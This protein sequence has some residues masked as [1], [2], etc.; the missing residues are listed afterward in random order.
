MSAPKPPKPPKPA[1]PFRAKPLYPRGPAA[2]PARADPAPRAVNPGAI[3]AVGPARAAVVSGARIMFEEDVAM[4]GS[5]TVDRGRPAAA[6]CSETAAGAVAA[7]KPPPMTP[8]WQ[9]ATK[10]PQIIKNL[11]MLMSC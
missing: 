1:K 10:Q 6:G 3:T 5:A 7:S 2:R 4:V 11:N 8:A 9:T